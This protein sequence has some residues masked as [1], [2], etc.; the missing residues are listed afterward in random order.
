M[1]WKLHVLSQIP[2]IT[3]VLDETETPAGLHRDFLGHMKT[4]LWVS[5]LFIPRETR[6]T[7]IGLKRHTTPKESLDAP[8]AHQKMGILMSR[9]FL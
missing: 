5:A 6:R 2:K 4:E 9:L 3:A 7:F 8:N 1:P